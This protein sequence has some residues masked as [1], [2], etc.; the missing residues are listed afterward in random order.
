MAKKQKKP[1]FGGMVFVYQLLMDSLQYF[2][3]SFQLN[4]N[5]ARAI[6]VIASHKE[7]TLKELCE[8]TGQPKS[9]ASRIV[10]GLVEQEMVERV[11]PAENRRIVLL[12]IHPSFAKRLEKM[13][14]DK[15]FQRVLTE[16]LP[17]EQMQLVIRKL[18]ELMDAVH[19]LDPQD[20][21]SWNERGSHTR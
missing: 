13:G 10:D 19:G 14:E 15:E 1:S 12:T 4:T 21:A 11:I 8:Y 16:N 20:A 5:Q 3:K 9:T 2:C 18:G 7:M 6:L 17:Q